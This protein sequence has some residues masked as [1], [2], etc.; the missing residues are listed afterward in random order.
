MKK[1]I[2]PVIVVFLFCLGVCNVSYTQNN[3]ETLKNVT[4]SKSTEA[5]V[6]EKEKVIV[7]Q[8]ANLRTENETEMGNTE[9]VII[10]K[11][12]EVINGYIFVGDS[13]FVGMN[14]VCNID[15]IDNY[16]V[17]AKVGQGYNWY[18]NEASDE[19]NS[20]VASNENVDSWNIVIG[21]GVNDLGNVSNYVELYSELAQN[22]NLFVV[23]VN[24]IEYHSWITNEDIKY[25]NAEISQIENASYIDSYNYL[26]TE[27]FETA[28][29]LHYKNTTYEKI[30]DFIQ[31]NLQ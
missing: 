22:Y 6:A 30:F 20:I 13:R 5:E 2:L 8:E 7:H 11:Q 12:K 28:D 24:P 29:G 31:N 26:M 21:L 10:E 16:Y 18:L 1:Y 4:D 9:D 23:S 27:G 15:E 25:F 3:T 19:I 14:D 17:V